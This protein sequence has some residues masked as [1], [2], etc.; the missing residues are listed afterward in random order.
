MINEFNSYEEKIIY[1]SIGDKKTL[2]VKIA[3]NNLINV[4]SKKEDEWLKFFSV[5][6][7]IKSFRSP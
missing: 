1:L 7:K 6:L 2:K 3:S 5:H 4:L